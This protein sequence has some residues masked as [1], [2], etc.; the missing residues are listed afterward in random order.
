MGLD[1]KTTEK[2]IQILKE[3]LVPALGCTEPIA[4]A[5]TGASL[6]KIMGGIPDEILIESSGNIIK[7]AKSVIVPNTG[8]MKGMEASALIGII[9]GNPDKGLEVL[10]DVTSDDVKTAEKYLQKKC[11]KIQLMDTPATLHIKITGKLNGNTGIAELIHQH[12]NLVLL[13]LNDEIILKKSYSPEAASGDLTDRSCLNVKDILE[14]ANTV[15]L[16]S[17][18]EP[19]LRQI[20]YNTRVAQ[21][22]LTNSYGVETGKNILKYSQRKGDAFSIKIQAEGEVA[23]ASDARM[24]GCSY[25]VITNSGSGNQGLAV[26]VPVIV[27][28]REMGVSKEKLIRSLLISNLLAIHQKTGIGRLSAYCGAV[29][30]GAACA[31]A[32]TYMKG[33][34]YDQ[35]CGTI[36]NALGTVS[37]IVCDGAKQS[38]ASKIAASLDSALFGHELAMDGKYFSGGDGIIKDDIEKTIAGVGVM[39]AEGMRQTDSVIL[40]VMLKD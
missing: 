12:T 18:E 37:G 3:E 24:C 31:A 27:Y 23:A 30:A 17:I 26:S 7:N 2:Y 13:K 11:T 35:I 19:I 25:P 4:I 20:E 22:G 36:K 1:E 34:S 5:Y 21:D 6:R 9:G 14:F 38:C 32:V 39:A 16:N 10:A 15:N 8:G 33:G 40:N 28:A 29:T